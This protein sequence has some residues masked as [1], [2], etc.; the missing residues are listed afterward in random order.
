MASRVDLHRILID[1][2]G[3]QNVY[4]QPPPDVRLRYP[5]IIYELS[6]EKINH[7]DNRPYIHNDRY[8]VT[9][10][11]R[12]PDSPIPHRVAQLSTCAF[13]RRFVVDGLYH[14]VYTIYY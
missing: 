11:D 13:D 12:D 1:I 14:T 9:V 8:S 4:Y 5:C 10:V 6:Y 3:S 2:L 7:A